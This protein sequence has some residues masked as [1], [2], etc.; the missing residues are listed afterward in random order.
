MILDKLLQSLHSYNITDIDVNFVNRDLEFMNILNFLENSYTNII[1]LYCPWGCGK[2]ELSRAII[3]VFE[4]YD[5][6]TNF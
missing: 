5:I 4:K 2:T 1:V 6:Y 3:Y